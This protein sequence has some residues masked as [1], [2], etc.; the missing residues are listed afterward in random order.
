LI[1][2]ITM[3]TIMMTSM[4]INTNGHSKPGRGNQ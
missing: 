2:L 4:M 1:G 3:I